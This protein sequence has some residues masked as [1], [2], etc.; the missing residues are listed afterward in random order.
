MSRLGHRG[1][2]GSGLLAYEHERGQAIAVALG[3]TQRSGEPP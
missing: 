1:V 2:D 3:Q